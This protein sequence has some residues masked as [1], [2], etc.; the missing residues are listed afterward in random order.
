M[1][2][3][4]LLIMKLAVFLTL[5]T[6]LQA[7]AESNAQTITLSARNLP[8]PKTMES[9]QTQSGYFFF[10]KGEELASLKVTT[11]LKDATLTE[12]MD[13]IAGN[14]GLEWV[15][16]GKTI[17][18]RA[19][20]QPFAAKPINDPVP[21]EAEIQQ[22]EI[23]G[24]V[25]NNR[26]EPLAGVTVS[27]KG[28]TAAVTTNAEGN[29][30][31]VIP[32]DGTALVFTS[33]GYNAQET[34]IGSSNVINIILNEAI[35][36]L[37]EVVVV[38]Y[39]TQKK[40]S[41]TAAITTVR[42]QDLVDVPRPNVLSALQGR[43][44][45]LTISETSGQPDASP[46]I[47]VRGIGTIDG[48]TGPLILVDGVPTATIGLIPANDI[49]SISVLKD[50]AAAAI[51][52]ARAANGVILVSTKRG[53]IN[54]EKPIIQF[55]SYFGA[56]TL[57]QSPQT[58]SAYQYASLLNEVYTNEGYDPVFSA[59]DIEM[60]QNGETDDFHGN[61]DWKKEVLR[62]VA[63][64][65]TNHLSVSGNG[66]LGRYYVSGEY[67]A[68]NGMVKEIDKYDRLNL[69]ANV[70][71]DINKHFQL[72]FITNYI[73]THKQ[74]GDLGHI[75]YATQTGAPI[76]PVKYSD[77]NWGSQ[78]FANGAY[79]WESGN[80][81]R[82]VDNYGPVDT[83]WNT[84]NSSG[85][86]SY[87]P[88][89]DL[90]F[91]GMLSYRNSWS[92]DQ[93]YSR[94]WFSW[95]PI[96]Q[97]ISQSGP[98]SL[99]EYWSKEYKYDL[100][101]T[102][103]Y[104]KSFGIHNFKMLAGYSQESLRS[105]F[106]S[107]FRQN[108]IND[109]LYEL[110]AGDAATQT[111][112][113]GADQWSFASFFG[114]LNYDYNSKYLFEANLRYD[115]SSRFAPGN[116][117]GLFPSVSVGWNM[118]QENF[119]KDYSFVDQLKL[120]L[121][122]GQLGNAEKVD[123]YRWF[124]GVASGPFYNFNGNLVSGTRPDYIANEDLVWETTTSYNVGLDASFNQG[125]YNF[126]VDFWHKNT[127]DV[128]L[129]APISTIIG[130][131]NSN[132]TVNAGKVASHGFDISAGTNGTI[133]QDLK[134]DVRLSFTAWNSWIVDLKERATAFS[135]EFRPGEDMGNYYGYQAIGIINDEA[136]L[137][138]YRKL[139]NVAPQVA[140]GDLQFKDQN[141]DGRLDYLDYVK[142]GNYNVKNNFGL[143]LG[144]GYK[145]F[146][147]QVFFQGAFNVDR[148]ILGETRTSFHNF[149]SPDANQLDRWTEQNRNADALYPRLRKEFSLNTEAP[150]SF[151]IKDASYV[152]LKNLQI[153]YTFPVAL[154]NRANIQTLRIYVAG[155][156]LFTIA[157][158]Y[159]EGYDPEVDMSPS[160]YPSLRVYSFGVNLKF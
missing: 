16:K 45:G 118:A 120:R 150:S 78:I 160:R 141:G 108:F 42:T 149:A 50:A 97:S 5:I 100:Q 154:L 76:L 123:L 15:L 33:V 40:S 151:W 32:Q 93:A 61:T 37:D 152:K 73:R 138:E 54:D 52:G 155:S 99:N 148:A 57:A 158:D 43:V 139:E 58:L 85:I 66:S 84:L 79:L 89:K 51:Y 7:A 86:L 6:V 82:I 142:I 41:M 83:Y 27:V 94:S 114:R 13:R 19:K 67:V 159:L 4:L 22:R 68:Q 127:N 91:K 1:T 134:Y 38:G 119:L 60:Y 133:G 9:I 2:N 3:Q 35:S 47:Q 144:L 46:S 63:P 29:Y 125:R 126:E 146:D 113:G 55:S 74:A 96:R 80:P 10:L 18:L 109:S 87:T 56:Q 132:M 17:I 20:E 23:S 71:S 21:E 106:I 92:D 77:G 103:D 53:M 36:D 153:G 102:A 26:D 72:Q 95:D 147:A 48:A 70:T 122:W 30:H 69:R 104:A 24:R 90:V 112:N 34:P 44:A 111:N 25:T 105:D 116:Q 88:I 75:F 121:S 115:G 136:T 49:E 137:D 107:A 14:L 140:L 62:S 98:A 39:G 130:A 31:I 135:T 117:W 124:S 145:A 143:N 65:V 156:N 157:P 64:I 12:A 129:S 81:T 128:L 110:D 131:P 101:L 11:T 8:L 28:T 59:R